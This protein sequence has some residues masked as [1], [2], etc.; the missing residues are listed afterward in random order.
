MITVRKLAIGVGALSALAS[1]AHAQNSA[2]ATAI[3]SATIIQPIQLS[4]PTNLGFG[5][6]VKPTGGTATVAVDAAGSRTVTGTAAANSA[7]VTAASFQVVGEGGSTYSVSVPSTFNMTSGSNSLTVTTVDNAAGGGTLSNAIGTQGTAT[8]GVGGTFNLNTA[9][10][11]GAYT[12]NIVVT[13][14][15]N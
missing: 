5:T 14:S 1:A 2:D 13:A 7:G 12:G 4:A 9:T 15:Y 10:V 3:G 11:S 8:F 6:I